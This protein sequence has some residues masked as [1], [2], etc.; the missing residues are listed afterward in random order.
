MNV[1]NIERLYEIATRDRGFEAV[2]APVY[3]VLS[4]EECKFCYFRDP[5]GILIEF[6]EWHMYKEFGGAP[7]IEAINHTAI[8][9][10][11]MDE[12]MSFYGDILGFKR[13]VFDYTGDMGL[14]APML[15]SPPPEMKL[16]MLS[17]SH[18]PGFIEIFQHLPPYKPPTTGAH[19]G[20][21][22]HMEFA[23]DVSNIEKAYD[24]LQRK[25]AKFLCPPQSIDLPPSGEWKY[26]YLAEPNGLNVS[27]VEH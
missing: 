15:P 7:T 8:G 14:M 12:S 13:E 22:G 24:E 23:I 20:D 2:L 26:A 18:R 25:G 16:K 6:I 9:V 27:L 21:I 5:D 4:G 1:L 11:D 19:W 3:A 17:N 10:R